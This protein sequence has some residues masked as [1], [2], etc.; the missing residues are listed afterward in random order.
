MRSPQ[1]RQHLGGL[2][3]TILLHQPHRRF[4]HKGHAQDE[5]HQDGTA[6]D[7]EDHVGAVRARH[8]REHDPRGEEQGKEGAEGAANRRLGDFAGIDR[9]EDAGR[10]GADPTDESGDVH[11]DDVPGR[12]QGDPARGERHSR[13]EDGPFPTD[14]IGNLASRHGA[15]DGTQRQQGCYPRDLIVAQLRKEGF[16]RCEIRQDRRRPTERYAGLHTA[17][18]SCK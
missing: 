11:T 8:I 2:D 9:H 18:R 3:L 13:Q 7:V 16:R 6:G 12:E 15:H 4:R 17:E 1:N 10:P 14:S 5:G